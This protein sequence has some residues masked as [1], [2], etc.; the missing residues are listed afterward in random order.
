MYCSLL[1]LSLS[2]AQVFPIGVVMSFFR[3]CGFHE[4]KGKR[5]QSKME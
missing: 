4:P 3:L 1:S 2:E 5:S